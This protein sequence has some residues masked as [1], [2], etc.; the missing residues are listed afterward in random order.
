M[1]DEKNVVD[2]VQKRGKDP[3]R[4]KGDYKCAIHDFVMEK[5]DSSFDAIRDT[6][7]QEVDKR[8]HKFEI[9]EQRL[10][11][12]ITKW[13]L[14]IIIAICTPLIGAMFGLTLW[15][16]QS[17]KGDIDRVSE[18]VIT[19]ALAQ[20]EFTLVMQDVETMLKKRKENQ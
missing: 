7:R 19:V 6:I 2:W 8:D 13:A 4:R 1:P 18:K 5:N 10:Q 20:A 9:L 3:G 15:Q 11:N 16:M 17:L 12:Y 14:G